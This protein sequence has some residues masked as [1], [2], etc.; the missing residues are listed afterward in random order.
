MAPVAVLLSLLTNCVFCSNA[1]WTY[2]YSSTERTGMLAS[3]TPES[4]WCTRSPSPTRL[5]VQIVTCPA[6]TRSNLCLIA[7]NRTPCRRH[8]EQD[9]RAIRTACCCLNSLRIRVEARANATERA[10]ISRQLLLMQA[11]VSTPPY[12]GP[13]HSWHKLPVQNLCWTFRW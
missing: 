8:H 10:V 1:D 13:Q 5:H 12:R 4:Q 6:D 3:G 9:C 7:A 2:R 11:S